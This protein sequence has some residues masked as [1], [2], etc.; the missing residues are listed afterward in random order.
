MKYK[1]KPTKAKKKTAYIT[2]TTII[3]NLVFF[4][5]EIYFG[6]SENFNT[7]YRLGALVPKEV[8]AG[9]WWRLLTANFLHFGEVHLFTNMLGLALF[10]PL[11]E[12]NLG[13]YRYLLAY[14]TIG[15]LSMLSF[16][17][18][19]VNFGYQNTLLVGASAAIMGLVGITSVIFF[20]DWR[21]SK[22][23]VAAKQLRIIVIII[24][25]QSIFDILIPQVSFLSHV[26]G[27]IIGFILGNILLLI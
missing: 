16:T 13:S 15:I 25:L 6:G 22:S 9:E 4:V 21:K 17:I 18:I 8:I 11:V 10:G 5:L 7:L 3:L 24:I 23:K 12:K 19:G 1:E 27:L 26:L 20:R 14:L 2:Y